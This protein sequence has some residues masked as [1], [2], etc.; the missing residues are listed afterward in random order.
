MT[1]DKSVK[2]SCKWEVLHTCTGN[3]IYKA[4]TSHEKWYYLTD[5]A[6]LALGEV[7][8]WDIIT[9]FTGSSACSAKHQ[10]LSYSDNFEFFFH[11]ATHC[12]N[13]EWNFA[14]TAKCQTGLGQKQTVQQNKQAPANH[15]HL[16]YCYGKCMSIKSK[17]PVLTS[18]CQSFL[19]HGSASADDAEHAY[20]VSTRPSVAC[21]HLLYP[22]AFLYQYADLCDVQEHSYGHGHANEQLQVFWWSDHFLLVFGY[23]ALKYAQNTNYFPTKL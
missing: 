14:W 22:C 4:T 7:Q 5:Q 20:D 3:C 17:L 19:L 23:S 10:Y 9:C 15:H 16:E 11:R 12:T 1:A 18:V 2:S 6:S 21:G 8:Y 13:G